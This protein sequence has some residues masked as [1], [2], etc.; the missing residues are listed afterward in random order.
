MRFSRVPFILVGVVALVVAVASVIPDGY[1]VYDSLWFKLLWGVV[2]VS[3]G[4]VA[5]R[6]RL[7]R[8]PIVFAIHLGL[9]V[10][11]AGALVTSLTGKKGVL[12]LR[13][14]IP[15]DRYLS[16]KTGEVV[17][18]PCLVRLDT[19]EI[20]YY[21]GTD[22][23]RDYVSRLTA[24][25]DEMVIS[26]NQ[27]GHL[28][29]FRLY[30][31]SYDE[32]LQGTVLSVNYDPWG[33]VVTYS[34]YLL[35]LLS[36]LAS[37]WKPV[38]RRKRG[39]AVALA[40]LAVILPA[41]GQD[42]PTITRKKADSLE[43]VQVMWNNRPCPIGTMS[44][45]F[46]QKVYGRKSYHG[47]TATQ[48][49]VSWTLAPREWNGVPIIKRKGRTYSK[50]DDFIDYSTPTPRLKGVGQDA[51]T[52]EKVALVLM[53]QQGTLVRSLPPEVKPL[54]ETH[55]ATELL[56]DRIPWM[57]VGIVLSVLTVVAALFGRRR[58][59]LA[60]KALLATLLLMHFVVL[61]Y[62]C[63]YVPLSNTYETL[64]FIAFFLAFL[65][66][67][68]TAVT[69]AVA[70]LIERNPQLTPLVPVLNSPWLSAHVSCV[71]LSYALLVASFFRRALLRYA[72]SLLA[73]GIF[74]GSV[75]ANVSWGAYWSWDPKESW[76]LITLLVYSIPLHSDTLPWFRS[77]RNYRLYSIL[78]LATLLM[79]YFG[80][81]YLLGGMHSYG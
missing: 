45:D 35:F 20:L 41:R 12:H 18:L 26:M 33:T 65:M 16:Q 47:L 52:D 19:F 74:L 55:V 64:L 34:G 40:L 36:F 30:Q 44:R 49:V 37:L 62:L 6:R 11:L 31:T 53:L 70:L 76:A 59:G 25:G 60:L 22:A 72:V 9:I 66:P 28:H 24:N 46:L 42:L 10:I 1:V 67:L 69:L 48:V 4:V 23:P 58:L 27:I 79:T 50:M 75:W 78:A 15:S 54:S 57:L 43:R 39:V 71:M 38:L 13:T 56:Y 32:D 80:V 17:K 21:P 61:W 2:A 8:R 63:G 73:V 51:A 29:G 7:W 81:N 3:G 68:G 5:W 77:Q 14:G